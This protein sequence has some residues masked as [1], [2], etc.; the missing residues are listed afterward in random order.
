MSSDD[1]F[2]RQLKHVIA[3]LET[4][5]KEMA[6]WAKIELGPIDGAW[7]ISAVPHAPTACPF[8]IILRP[9]RKF[10]IIVGGE[11]YE[12]QPFD[13]LT[14]I[15]QMVRSIS[16]GRVLIRRW[17]GQ[18]TGILYS[19]ETLI[20]LPGTNEGHFRRP[21]PDAP[22]IEG[23]EVEAELEAFDPYRRGRCY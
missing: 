4:W 20:D 5:A 3:A 21:N 14:D 18:A 11:I 13:A 6:P 2:R 8:E 12:D 7:R 1:T 16:N 23:V 17:R 9:D 10:D 15:P 22:S 19:T